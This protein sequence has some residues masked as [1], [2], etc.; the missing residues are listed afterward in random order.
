MLLKKRST[1]RTKLKATMTDTFPL[2]Y[3]V[4][5]TPTSGPSP[6][7]KALMK[8]SIEEWGATNLGIYNNR[9]IRGG[10]SLSKHARGEAGDSGFPYRV[11]GTDEGWRFANWLLAYHR[12]LGVQQVIYARMIWSNT[13][14][15]SG[16][17]YYNGTAAHYEH[18]HWELTQQAAAE[19]TTTM[20]YDRTNLGDKDMAIPDEA[21]EALL[22]LRVEKV[23]ELVAGRE[24]D[25]GGLRY[26]CGRVVEAHRA[27]KDL[28]PHFRALEMGLLEGLSG[29]ER[30]GLSKLLSDSDG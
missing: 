21:V 23:Y 29:A 13:K 17:R 20:I 2:V 3:D 18:V 16:W 24:A 12:E 4:A 25:L 30:D 28:T 22:I 11:G 14:D 9:S 10:L 1:L 15:Q 26:W 19:L 8:V 6:G 5:R 7:A 27:G